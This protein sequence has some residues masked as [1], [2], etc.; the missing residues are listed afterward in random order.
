MFEE[1]HANSALDLRRALMRLISRANPLDLLAD[2]RLTLPLP[3]EASLV[4][5]PFCFWS[6]AGAVHTDEAGTATQGFSVWPWVKTNGIP[7]WGFR[8]T[9]HF[10]GDWDLHW[11]FAVCVQNCFRAVARGVTS[12][13]PSLATVRQ[14]LSLRGLIHSPIPSN[15]ITLPTENAPYPDDSSTPSG[16]FS[17]WFYIP[18]Q[19]PRGLTTREVR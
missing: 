19:L 8:C 5:G 4:V 2:S 14:F 17:F 12:I 15:V 1:F 18:A 13:G 11:A 9:T 3:L 16:F 7:F 10:G 6:P